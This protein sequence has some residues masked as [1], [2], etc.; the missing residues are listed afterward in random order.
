LTFAFGSAP[1]LCTKQLFIEL[2]INNHNLQQYPYEKLRNKGEVSG[3]ETGATKGAFDGK[4]FKGNN[5]KISTKSPCGGR[6]LRVESGELKVALL[7]RIIAHVM[8]VYNF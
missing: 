1:K 6:H 5:N 3:E 7:Q 8:Q 4:G 2:P